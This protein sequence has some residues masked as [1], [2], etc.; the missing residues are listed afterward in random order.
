MTP[1]SIEKL[2]DDALRS[3]DEI[4]ATAAARRTLRTYADTIIPLGRAAGLAFA[5]EG[6]GGFLGYVHPDAEI[7]LA[8][9]R[10]FEKLTKWRNS[11]PRRDDVAQRDRGVRGDRGGAIAQWPAR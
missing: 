11:V 6:R 9:R 7:R 2:T 5:A 1:E 8:G 3:A 10:A 4:I